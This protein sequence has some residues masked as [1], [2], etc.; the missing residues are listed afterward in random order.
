MT[1]D[2]GSAQGSASK[3]SSQKCRNPPRRRPRVSPRRAVAGPKRRRRPVFGRSMKE[4]LEDARQAKARRKE[5]RAY[6]ALR[7]G[8]FGLV[9]RQE[10]EALARETGFMCREPQ[11][12]PPFEF[13][14]CCA[15][16]A[17]T[18]MKRGFATVW[19]VLG[20]VAGITVARSAV[21]QRFGPGSAKLMETLFY[22][23][24]NRLPSTA[25]SEL[26]T[27]LNQFREVLAQDGTVLQLS[28]V[29]EKL[30]PA[31]RTNVV[32]AAAKAHVTANVVSRRIIDVTLTGE[33]GSEL[34]ELYLHQDFAP[35]TLYL[36]D[37]GYTSYDLFYVIKKS[38][39]FVLMRLKENANPKVVAIRQGVRAPKRSIGRRLK[40]IA[41]CTTQD[42]FDLDA[43]FYCSE[44]DETVTMRVV[45]LW[46][47][48]TGRYHCYVTN[49]PPEEWSIEELAEL[50]RQ[51]WIIELLMKLLKSGCHLDHL[52]TGNPDALRTL[53][54]AS[55]LAAVVLQAA[56]L[57]ASQNAGIPLEQISFLTVGAAAPLLAVPLLMLWLG[58]EVSQETLSQMIMRI[59]VYGCR[60][61][62]P[63]RTRRNAAPLS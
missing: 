45:G 8:V 11:Q 3:K 54:Y 41:F 26:R 37:L 59:I 27:K 31:T 18:E 63:G 4:R 44:L 46:N 61:Q 16:A 14:L 38:D 42:R 33:R 36:L 1:K 29:L 9:N 30:F 53:I 62:N 25:H 28:P 24:V 10:A 19:R 52:D 50:Y 60:D 22:R 35:N 51:R 47:P 5:R 17:V 6:R 15:L 34:D 43:E 32:D 20:S 49:L 21:T 48:A 57:T 13:V 23:A 40:D 56:M 7:E 12:I 2:T 58:R 39:A 55:L